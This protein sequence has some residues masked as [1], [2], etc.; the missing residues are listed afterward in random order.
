M[1]QGGMNADATTGAVRISACSTHASNAMLP[2][3][4]VFLAHTAERRAKAAMYPRWGKESVGTGTSRSICWCECQKKAMLLAWFF[5]F[6]SCFQ[7]L[8]LHTRDT[9]A[10]D[11][12]LQTSRAASRSVSHIPPLS[13]V[14]Q[15]C[16]RTAGILNEEKETDMDT[17]IEVLRHMYASFNARDIDGV[18]AQLADDVTWANGMEG[19]YVQGHEAVG[20]YWTRQ[21]KKPRQ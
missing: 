11:A 10:R 15:Q 14:L 13:L 21:W 19:G 4:R 6:P 5:S 7:H 12:A 8:C 2:A 1:V 18:L 20:E 9:R 16:G 3:L 17:P